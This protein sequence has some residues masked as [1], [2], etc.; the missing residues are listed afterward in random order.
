MF[1]SSLG[2]M[3][4]EELKIFANLILKILFISPIPIQRV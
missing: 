4:D 3:N 1:Y 2:Q